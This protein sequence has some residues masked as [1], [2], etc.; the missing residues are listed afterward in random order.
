MKEVW[1]SYC[2]PLPNPLPRRGD[3]NS[4][5]AIYLDTNMNY[6]KKIIFF[7]LSLILSG[8]LSISAQTDPKAK[9]VLDQMS[10]KAKTYSSIKATFSYAIDNKEQNVH[11][12]QNGT[13][14]IKGAKYH[15]EFSG[16]DIICD[17]TSI[18]TYMKDANEVQ[19]T[20]AEYD[21]DVIT[22][23]NIFT[24]YQKGYKYKYVEEKLVNNKPHHVIDLFPETSKNFFRARL[25]IDKSTLTLSKAEVSDKKGTVYTYSIANLTSNIKLDNTAFS[26]NKAKYPGVEVVD[27]RD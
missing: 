19:I 20:K 25:F 1:N 7:T 22:P 4:I 18:W 2:R 24:M 3:K 6:M 17:S 14:T 23:V 15:L 12:K 9:E 10:K 8:T 11:E 5:K 16:Q 27:M 21:D 26:F 13:V